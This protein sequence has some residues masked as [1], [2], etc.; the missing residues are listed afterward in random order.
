MIATAAPASYE[1]RAED[2]L[3]RTALLQQYTDSYRHSLS[4]VI[5]NTFGSWAG[6]HVHAYFYTL[7]FVFYSM[8]ALSEQSEPERYHK[9]TTICVVVFGRLLALD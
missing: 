8:S 3:A 4:V 7:L 9:I 2:I 1:Q 5:A 6:S